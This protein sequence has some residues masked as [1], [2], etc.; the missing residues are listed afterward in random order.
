MNNVQ[1]ITLLIVSLTLFNTVNASDPI[2][3]TK[4][5]NIAGESFSF[6]LSIDK[7]LIQHTIRDASSTILCNSFQHFI[8][9]SE[10]KR[11]NILRNTSLIV[12]TSII[13]FELGQSNSSS[14]YVGLA[15]ITIG[16]VSHYISQQISRKVF[17]L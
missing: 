9:R 3:K 15:D 17:K 2:F 6:G 7:T 14:H 12:V 4:R 11:R 1:R 8:F 10:K 13:A 5:L 16:I